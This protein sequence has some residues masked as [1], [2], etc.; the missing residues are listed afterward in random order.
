MT[1]IEDI[2][3]LAGVS[4]STVSNAFNNP[5]AL[6]RETRQRILTIS[7]QHHYRPEYFARLATKADYKLVEFS[8]LPASSQS[9]LSYQILKGVLS[10]AADH[11][12]HILVKIRDK[13][14]D[15][16][17]EPHSAPVQAQ[18]ILDPHIRDQYRRSLPTI[19]IGNPQRKRQNISVINNNNL[20]L[21]EEAVDLLIHFHHRNLLFLN[22]A[23][24][25]TVAHERLTGF[26]AALH[27]HGLIFSALNHHMVPDQDHP[28]RYV[29]QLLRN[30]AFILNN[31]TAIIC[32]S[33]TMAQGVYQALSHLGFHIPDDIS[34]LA[35]SC[36]NDL[37]AFQPSLS[38][39]NLRPQ[40][41]GRAALEQALDQIDHKRSRHIKI[42]HHLVAHH[43]ITYAPFAAP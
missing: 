42:D 43:S 16:N 11:Q 33:S 7:Q 14:L 29:N 4:K 10:Y 8:M 35:L 28:D 20:D 27:K 41:I 40:E 15:R 13:I 17:Q 21:M 30:K 24:T 26:K 19:L 39:F 22:T 3:R 37:A 9:P 2:A 1:T 23:K 36:N 38:Y 32:D 18:I 31:I 6:S 34:V 25:Q 12:V 5:E